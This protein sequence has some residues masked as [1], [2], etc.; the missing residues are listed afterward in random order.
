MQ[1]KMI[2]DFLAGSKRLLIV[3]DACRFDALVENIDLLD[4]LK[5]TVSRVR[6]EGSCT[7][8]W[9]LK[10]FTEPLDAVY[11]SA[12]PWVPK[13]LGG[14]GVFG[15]I[16]DV[17]A[18]YWDDGVGTVRAEYVN[19][20]AT[21]YLFKGKNVVVHYL[22]PHPPFVV[23]TWLRDGASPKHLTGSRI[24]ELATRNGV[25]RREFRRAYIENLRYV[26][27]RAKSLVHVALRLGYLVAITSDHGELFGVYAPIATLKLFLRKNL[28]EFLRNWLPYAVGRYRLVGHPCGLHCRE[29]IEVPWV[30]IHG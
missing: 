2:Y 9:L 12:N 16:V 7:S 6:S 5:Y 13:L 23:D 29:L 3:L 14:S 21:R 19:V 17:S 8:E 26:L 11:V 25:A 1:K 30:E 24:Y 28:V 15:E 10:T 20:V 18:R 4:G 27:R 22:Q